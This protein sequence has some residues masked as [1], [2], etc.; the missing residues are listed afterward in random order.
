[1][2]QVDA[3]LDHV[4]PVSRSK[5]RNESQFSI[6]DLAHMEA[7]PVRASLQAVKRSPRSDSAPE[8]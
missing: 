2:L 6:P 4:A 1:M 5:R 3:L 7:V 8:A